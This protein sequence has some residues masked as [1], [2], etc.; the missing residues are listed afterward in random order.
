MERFIFDYEFKD[1]AD[2]VNVIYL[3]CRRENSINEILY[4]D[5]TIGQFL[6][7][8]Y[9]PIALSEAL[10]YYDLL[11]QIDIQKGYF[12]IIYDKREVDGECYILTRVCDI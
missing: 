3:A 4:W 9:T 10:G 1:Y 2:N 8:D 11:F 12:K 5:S 7:V 6:D